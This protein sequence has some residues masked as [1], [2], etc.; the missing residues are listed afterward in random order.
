LEPFVLEMVSGFV[1]STIIVVERPCSTWS[2]HKMPATVF[3]ISS[4]SN[5]PADIAILHPERRI[6]AVFFCQ[7]RNH[8]VTVLG[9]TVR[10][11]PLSPQ[12]ETD[13]PEATRKI[14]KLTNIRRHDFSQFYA[15]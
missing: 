8:L 11:P 2:V 13:A 1:L 7:W 15:T 10:V 9:A 3:F 6:D 14:G 5:N 4:E 12:L